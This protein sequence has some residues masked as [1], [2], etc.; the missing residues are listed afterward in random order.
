MIQR[1]IKYLQTERGLSKL[2][3]DA[4]R[5]DLSQWADFATSSGRHPLCPETTSV[6]DIRLW[7][8]S[9]TRLGDSP[10]TVRRKLQALRAFFRYLMKHHGLPSNPASEVT[11]PKTP[12]Q[13]PVSLRQAE[14][15]AM[16]DA[17]NA[18]A[19]P[20]DFESVRN[21]LI[22]DMFYSTGIRCS[23]L[24]TLLD[25]HV[26]TVKGELKVLGK[27]NKERIVPF[28]QELTQMINRYRTLRADTIG[29]A[30]PVTFFVNPLGRPLGRKKV[31]NVV[32]NAMQGRVH[33]S[34]M[35]PHV[36]RHSFATDMLNSGAQLTSVQ[37]LLGHASLSTTQIYTHISFRELKQ[38][39]Q[40][41]HP[42]AKNKGG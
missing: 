3:V 8:A 28:G 22:L 21:A 34:R 16:I 20:N 11:A 36:L 37:Q 4:Y 17:E 35:S 41:A 15:M 13:L 38:N 9:L 42:R 14:T 19:P 6:S 27:R 2:T 25:C 32:H 31:Y 33:A 7:I 1:F 5:R 18:T 12:Q 39:Y 24:I 10:R 30:T 26:D 23:E 29:T 40:L